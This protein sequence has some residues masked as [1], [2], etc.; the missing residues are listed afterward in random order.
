MKAKYKDA[1]ETHLD[2]R[3]I[4]QD[5]LYKHFK[6]KMVKG[7]KPV[8]I[9]S[10]CGSENVRQGCP[11]CGST[12]IKFDSEMQDVTCLNCGLVLAEAPPDYVDI[13]HLDLPWGVLLHRMLI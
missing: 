6:V 7:E 1:D 10:R 2:Y 13:T 3:L 4:C 8:L 11:E 5:C 9:C 12:N